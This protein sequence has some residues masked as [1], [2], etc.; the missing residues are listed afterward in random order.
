LVRFRLAER[1]EV[2]VMHH[3]VFACDGMTRAIRF[4]LLD[5]WCGG[6]PDEKTLAL[7]GAGG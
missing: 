6:Q 4:T 2:P 1:Y 3:A 5:R 7:I